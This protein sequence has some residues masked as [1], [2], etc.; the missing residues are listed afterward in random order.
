MNLINNMSAF[1]KSFIHYF[2]FLLNFKDFKEYQFSPFNIFKPLHRSS[3]KRLKN[4][5]LYFENFT[6]IK[7]RISDGSL[8]GILRDGKLIEH[9]NDIDFDL[10]WSKKSETLIQQASRHHGWKLIRKVKYKGRIQQLTYYDDLE[11]IYDFIFWS[12]DER[13]AINFSEPNCFRIM[14]EK[15]L[16]DLIKENVEGFEYLVPK[17][18][19]EWLDYRYGENWNIPETKKKDWK[20]DCGDIGKA[21]WI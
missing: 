8:L 3:L 2:V 21:W 16:T 15:F 5:L 14:S 12:L 18:K 7:I 1:L 13:F 4:L 10:I 19:F 20:I 6:E 17:D 9:D 11:I